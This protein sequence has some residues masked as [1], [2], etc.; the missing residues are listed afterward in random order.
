MDVITCHLGIPKGVFLNGEASRKVLAYANGQ[1]AGQLALSLGSN[2]KALRVDHIQE[3][4]VVHLHH[5]MKTVGSVV[6]IKI[7][8]VCAC[9]MDEHSETVAAE[10]VCREI[11]ETLYLVYLGN[12][13]LG[14]EEPK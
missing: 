7:V 2:S 13:V 14:L 3:T 6:T 11:N 12:N 9:Y 1:L 4:V 10:P 8:R 5:I